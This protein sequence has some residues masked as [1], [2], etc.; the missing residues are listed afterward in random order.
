MFLLHSLFFIFSINLLSLSTDSW[1][2]YC[3]TLCSFTALILVRDFLGW[4][5]VSRLVINQSGTGPWFNHNDKILT[6][7][8]SPWCYIGRFMT[9]LTVLLSLKTYNFSPLAASNL[10]SPYTV[11]RTSYGSRAVI[12]V[13]PL[14]WVFV[15]KGACHGQIKRACDLPGVKGSHFEMFKCSCLRKVHSATEL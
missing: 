3:C 13:L 1:S 4:L 5:D 12:K 10:S 9:C 8:T 15:M 14:L 7:S 2:L 6:A 11:Q